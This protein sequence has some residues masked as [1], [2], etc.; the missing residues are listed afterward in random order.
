LSHSGK[1]K[2]FVRDLVQKLEQSGVTIWLDER[3]LSIGDSITQK[4]G[5]AIDKMDYFAVVLSN[6]SINSAWVQKEIQDALSK[7]LNQKR[8][9]VL[10]LLL[11]EVTVP[12]FLKDKVFADFTSKDKFEESFQKLLKAVLTKNRAI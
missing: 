8:V 9:V 5:L 12:P 11:E 6:N 10:P 1:D 3:E 2:P 7:E 4:I